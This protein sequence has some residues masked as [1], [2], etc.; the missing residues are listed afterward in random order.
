MGKYL[1]RGRLRGM[2]GRR[3]MGSGRLNARDSMGAQSTAIPP[4]SSGIVQDSLIETNPEEEFANLKTQAEDLEKQLQAI[5]ARIRELEGNTKKIAKAACV[6]PAR[7]IACGICEKVCPSAAISI[8]AGIACIDL[9][10]CT[11][12]G[13]CV[14]QCPQGA[15]WMGKV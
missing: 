9:T 13:R 15:L 3:G 14:S 10:K 1:R 4:N 7:C 6:D 2:G 12:C 8:A 5:N 11:G